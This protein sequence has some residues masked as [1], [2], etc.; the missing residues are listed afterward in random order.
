M[1]SNFGLYFRSFLGCLHACMP[2][3]TMHEF[4]NRYLWQ[5][6][7]RR[8]RRKNFVQKHR[9]MHLSSMSRISSLCVDGNWTSLFRVKF[10]W[11]ALAGLKKIE[12][13]TKRMMKKLIWIVLVRWSLG[14]FQSLYLSF[15]SCL[16]ALVSETTFVQCVYTSKKLPRPNHFGWKLLT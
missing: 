10:F 9:E 7:K 12:A 14:C 8:M 15:T 2:C 16:F 3:I 11:R 4:D 5:T 1:L 13:A 6:L